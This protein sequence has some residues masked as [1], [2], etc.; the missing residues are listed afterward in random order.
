[1]AYY[2][3]LQEYIDALERNGVLFRVK[4]AI[5]KDTEMH[6]LVRWQFRGLREELRQA[7]YFEQAVDSRGKR[8]DIPVLI[9]GLAA[10]QRVYALGLKCKETEV[11]EVW[12]SALE[13]P[14]DP[15]LTS[16][17][18]VKELIYKGADLL[19]NG[20]LE[21]LPVPISTPGFDNAPYLTAGCWITK[22]PETGVRNMAIYRGQ[23]KGPLK[24]GI[25]WG[26]L[27][28]SA[29]HWEKCK[30]LGVPLEAAVVIGGPP[31]I[32]YAA[33]Q[34][35]ALGVDELSIAGGLAREPL[36]LVKC[37]TVD[38]EVPAQ[39]D[40]VIEGKIPTNYL[41][42]DGPFGESHG[43]EDPGDLT[44]AFEVT[45]ITQR[46]N[47]VF[48]SLISQLTPSESSKI[49][50]SAFEAFALRHLK[51][52][53]GDSIIKTSLYEDLLNRQMVV[54]QVQKGNPETNWL[55]MEE[56]LKTKASG[57]FIVCV[58]PDI[59]PT[60]LPSV[61]WA[62]VNR[63]QPHRD[64]K[65]VP[66]RPLPWN[67]TRFVADGKCYDTTD[68]SLLIDA[69][70]K[71]AFPPVA[72]PR[73]EFMERARLI[74]DELGLPTLSPREPWYGYSLGYWP[75]EA[76]AQ[77]ENAL[78]G[79]YLLNADM[80]RSRGIEVSRDDRFVDLKKRFLSGQLAQMINGTNGSK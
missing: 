44:A 3:N 35:V 65:I 66:N 22:D 56:L 43:Y 45:C 53:V 31:C 26:S 47:P 73:R 71:A 21:Q 54:I 42:P 20:G 70:L 18:P 72:L 74:W 39:A 80:L 58:D 13:H 5:N 67:P 12:R 77:A 32:A 14:I 1:M 59:D 40:I 17:G 19:S 64:A 38:L 61:M 23:I 30:R 41:E 79:D 78:S 75:E 46:R 49:K 15:I 62:I 28:D 55:A 51:A 6:P 2:L 27:K 4:R 34:R 33:V 25:S 16:Y 76:V 36:E 63:S 48:V 37:E 52:K 69:T 50:Q 9:G 68:S 29:I 10:S 8:F 60:D 24:T 11:A 57:K 7:F